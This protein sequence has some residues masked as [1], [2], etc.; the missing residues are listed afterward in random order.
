MI[1][2]KGTESLYT[3]ED[4][5]GFSDKLVGDGTLPRRIDLILLGFSYA[6]TQGLSPVETFKRHELLKAMSVNESDRRAVEA[7]AQWYAKQQG[8]PTA[9]NEKGL[10]D[11]MCRLGIAGARELR[12]RWKGKSKSQIQWDIL[13][14]ATNATA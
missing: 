7:V 12:D 9:E 13:Q 6:V 11:L 8:W 1:H 10:L 14:M 5:A 2:L 3:S 4:L